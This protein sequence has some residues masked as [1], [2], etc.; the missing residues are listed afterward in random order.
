[1]S[2]PTGGKAAELGISN[3]DLGLMVNVLVDGAKA[4]DYRYEGREIDLMVKADEVDIAQRTH[5]VEQLPLAAP[6]ASW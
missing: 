6:R 4:S 1:M 5:L 3:R 2:G